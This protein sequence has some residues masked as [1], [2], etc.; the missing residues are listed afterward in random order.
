MS[1]VDKLVEAKKSGEFKN[2]DVKGLTDEELRE[3]I[4]KVIKG[5]TT[6]KACA[7]TAWKRFT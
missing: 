5:N 7:F 1:K 2:G 6:M 4:N 3:F